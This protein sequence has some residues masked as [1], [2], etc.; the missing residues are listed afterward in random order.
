VTP[1]LDLPSWPLWFRLRAVAGERRSAVTTTPRRID[2]NVGIGLSGKHVDV[3]VPHDARRFG[4]RIVTL[5]DRAFERYVEWLGAPP[6][7]ERCD[8]RFVA[9]SKLYWNLY[10]TVRRYERKSPGFTFA[11]RKSGNVASYMLLEYGSAGLDRG[12]PELDFTTLHELSHCVVQRVT[13]SYS[14]WPS[15]WT[16]GS[17]DLFAARAISEFTGVPREQIPR[18]AFANRDART[19]LA[20][21][22]WVPLSRLFALDQDEP[23]LEWERSATVYLESRA[24]LNHLDTSPET[25]AKL[26]TFIKYVGSLRAFLITSRIANRF[27]ELFGDLGA[28]DAAL[29]ASLR[30]GQ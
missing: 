4:E 23:K 27:R 13:G 24:L 6:L 10:V 14:D 16:E 12:T 19:R 25:H 1:A 20:Q 8:L 26:E 29:Q 28:V 21:G 22:R 30:S 17:A 2:L 15:W 9:V 11:S 7:N 3:I 18:V 5:A